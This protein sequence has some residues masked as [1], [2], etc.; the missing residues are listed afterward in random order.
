M[1]ERLPTDIDYEH[2]KEHVKMV[3]CIVEPT[4]AA[5]AQAATA[6]EIEDVQ[7]SVQSPGNELS[8]VPPDSPQRKKQKMGNLKTG[9]P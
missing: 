4:Q 3:R 5:V 2:K 6:A 8:F 9:S 7:H 1:V